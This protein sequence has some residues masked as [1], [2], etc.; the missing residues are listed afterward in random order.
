MYNP[1]WETWWKQHDAAEKSWTAAHPG[2]DWFDSIEYRELDERW[3]ELDL[4]AEDS[5]P[6]CEGY[7]DADR[8]I[9]NLGSLGDVVADG[10]LSELLATAA[11]WRE[12]SDAADAEKLIQGL[13]QIR[14]FVDTASRIVCAQLSRTRAIADSQSAIGKEGRCRG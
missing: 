3:G 13:A 2:E 12:G 5:C 14:A 8:L 11:R 6:T 10:E 9:R 1:Y 7:G 4:A